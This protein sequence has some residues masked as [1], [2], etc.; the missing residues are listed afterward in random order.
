VWCQSQSNTPTW[1]LR[2][3][4]NHNRSSSSTL[5]ALKLWWQLCS[6]LRRGRWTHSWL[7]TCVCL[8]VCMSK[9]KSRSA[10]CTPGVVGSSLDET[11]WLVIY[12]N[13]REN[14][15]LPATSV[16]VHSVARTTSPSTKNVH[17]RHTSQISRLPTRPNCHS[18][19]KAAVYMT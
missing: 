11:S 1:I 14:A 2:V 8:C 19:L 16:A 18:Q 6:C 13:T 15:L 3:S 12:A 5:I 17:T 7:V 9:V 10:V 4:C